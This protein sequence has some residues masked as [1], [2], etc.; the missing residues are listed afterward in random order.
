M[1]CDQQRTY[2]LA[3]EAADQGVLERAL[4][5]SGL[6]VHAGGSVTAL[7]ASIIRTGQV[8]FTGAYMTEARAEEL[9]TQLRVAYANEAIK[10]A[11]K[12][13]GWTVTPVKGKA[14]TYDVAKARAF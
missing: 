13:Y 5:Q 8:R 1:P 12:R 14:N 2:G 9:A 3:F 4:Q 10:T 11:A 7:A 6:H